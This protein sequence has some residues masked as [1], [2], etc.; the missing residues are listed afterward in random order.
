MNI[1]SPLPAAFLRVDCCTTETFTHSNR[2]L[3]LENNVSKQITIGRARE[4]QV[5]TVGESQ[6]GL[7]L[8][9][10][11]SEIFSEHS[12]SFL[13]RLVEEGHVRLDT[14]QVRKTSHRVELGQAI[15]IEFPEP[16]PS[17]LE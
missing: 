8:D 3:I 7:R 6:A 2:D 4:T 12:R 13:A 1:I 14:E 5:A 10:A 11:L 16:A 17:E 15:T 9:R